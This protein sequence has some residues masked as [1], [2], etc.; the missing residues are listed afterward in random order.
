VSNPAGFPQSLRPPKPGEVR[1]KLGINGWTKHRPMVE[2]L[3]RFINERPEARLME[4]ARI[5][6]CM[7][8][9][10]REALTL[11]DG[12][13][14]KP[15]FNF[16]KELLDRL[17][18]K[19]PDQIRATGECRVTVVADREPPTMTEDQINDWSSDRVSMLE[20]LARQQA[21][22]GAGGGA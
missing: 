7:A 21:G 8:T 9:G 6:Y 10:H 12:T 15:D 14:L 1:N 16:F 4:L 20:F 17:D 5:F 18:G 2:A 3:E 22:A 19:V 13:R 11:P